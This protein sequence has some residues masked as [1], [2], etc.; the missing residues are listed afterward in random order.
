[1]IMMKILKVFMLVLVAILLFSSCE[2]DNFEAPKS[3]LTGKIVYQGKALGLRT[4]GVQLELWQH[5]YDLFN[6]IPVYVA[7][8]GSFSAE[9]F[10]G[11]YKLT[12][13][14]G[15]GPW[16]ES[17]DSLDVKVSGNTTVD[18]PVDPYFIIEGESFRQ[19]GD[20]INADLTIRH[21]NTSRDLDRVKLYIGET[22]FVDDIL[23]VSSVEKLA[24]DVDID[25]SISLATDI[26]QTLRGKGYAFVRIGV[27]TIGVAEFIY[28]QPVRVEFN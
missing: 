21:I 17:L 15:N 24:A 13:V 23:N 11:D 16:A 22:V 1:M 14:R 26:P 4:D 8:D 9:L 2:K 28:S 7:Q 18:F 3:K 20:A 19:N 25:Q 10:D 12:L 27:K 5:G 6:K